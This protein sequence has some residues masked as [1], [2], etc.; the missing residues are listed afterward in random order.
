MGFLTKVR[1][2][3]N[4]F[5]ND[6]FGYYDYGPQSSQAPH[7]TY[8]RVSNGKTIISSIYTRISIDLALVSL[9]HAKL[10][11]SK[12]YKED[13]DSGLSNCLSLS[14]N[15]DQTP[16]GL[17]Q[18]VALTLFDSGVAAIVPVDASIHPVTDSI[19]DIH[20]L[21]VGEI[22][23]WYPRHVRVS[24]Y[25]ERKGRREEIILPKSYVAIVPNPLYSVMN[26]SNSTLQRLIS[27]LGILDAIDEQSGSGKLDLI[28]QL[29]YAVKSET[30]KTQAENR[31]ANLELQL[32]GS[33]YGIAYT[34]ATEK[35]TQLNRPAENNL[36]TQV[37]YL[38]A[39]LYGQLGITEE[40]MNGTADTK[41]MLNYENRTLIPILTALVQAMQKTFIGKDRTDSG[42]K[43][44]YFKDPFKLVPAS[45]LASLADKFARNEILT[46]NEIRGFLGMPPSTDPKADKLVNSNMPQE[47]NEDD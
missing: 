35:I 16:F 3:W 34:D 7:R 14:P 24:L 18:D 41:T 11:E 5:N 26:E 25:D 20:S 27:K 4:V 44:L 23:N 19:Q 22:K 13:I 1:N 8:M 29:P 43:I 42:E 38:T 39:M 31:R 28:I 45:E 37:E 47:K 40:V 36:L 17:L 30:R 46:A 33:K 12:R 2:A 21:R 6:S 10:D 15:T 9:R 32:T